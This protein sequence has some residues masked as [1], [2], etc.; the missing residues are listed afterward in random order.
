MI[1]HHSKMYYCILAG[2]VEGFGGRQTFAAL[3][4]LVHRLFHRRVTRIK[5]ER[6][7]S[8]ATSKTRVY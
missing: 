5:C 8:S 6:L 7:L 4:T 2:A 3:F 1:I